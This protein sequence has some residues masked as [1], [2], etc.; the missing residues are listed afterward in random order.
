MPSL[1]VQTAGGCICLRVVPLALLLV[2]CSEEGRVS[3]EK[4]P[5][6]LDVTSGEDAKTDHRTT[7]D[8]Q[9]ALDPDSLRSVQGGWSPRREEADAHVRVHVRKLQ[10]KLRGGAHRHGAGHLE[11]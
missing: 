11:G 2:Y 6:I 8:S 7:I 4:S 1:T 10:E 9:E 5:G 3:N